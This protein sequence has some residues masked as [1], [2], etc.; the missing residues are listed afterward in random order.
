MPVISGLKEFDIEFPG[1]P[2]LAFKTAEDNQ[3]LILRLWNVR[4]HA[5]QGSLKLPPGWT[6]AEKCDAL[7][8]PVELLDVRENRIQFNAEPLGILTIALS[9]GS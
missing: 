8:R 4:N 1:G 9:K 6:Q 7:E 2:L 3:R 5:A